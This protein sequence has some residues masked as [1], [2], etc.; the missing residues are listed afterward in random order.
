M[1]LLT[2]NFGK[3]GLYLLGVLLVEFR[4]IKAFDGNRMVLETENKM[5]CSLY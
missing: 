2:V 3:L 1:G 5:E 4:P